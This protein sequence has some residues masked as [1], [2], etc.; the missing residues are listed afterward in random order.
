VRTRVSDELISRVADR[1]MAYPYQAWGFGEAVAMRALLAAGR[2]TGDLRYRRFVT[3]QFARWRAR[4]SARL[5]YADHV[6]PGVPLLEL[7]A[8]DRRWMSSA[9]A[10]AELFRTCP[11]RNGL[12]L[13]RPDLDWWSTH[14]WVDCLYTDGAFLAL[15]ARHT[16]QPAWTDLAAQ[17]VLAYVRV[18]WDAAVDLFVHGYDAATGQASPVHWGRG[19]GWALLGLL[20]FLRVLPR[21]HP[22]WPPLA[23]IVERHVRALLALQDAD[24]HW[25]TV[26]DRSDTPLESSVAAMMAYGLPVV[27]RLGLVSPQVAEVADRALAAALARL[28]ADGG[29]QGTSAATPIGDLAIYTG[30]PTGVFPWGQGPL[31][32]ALVDRVAPDVCWEDLQ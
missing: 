24:G 28:D 16:R 9:S 13:H 11:R 22:A 18:L 30:R 17:H 15:W 31:L 20:D 3:D 26:L 21:S 27:A 12:M 19:N 14:I 5:T 32:L 2:V 7:A 1:T 4:R 8:H 10:L 25:H 6:T 29:L 23:H